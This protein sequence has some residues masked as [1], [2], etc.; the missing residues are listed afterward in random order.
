MEH[1]P[2]LQQLRQ[3]RDEALRAAEKGKA[4]L[5]QTRAEV[6][7]AR[8]EL[9]LA[10]RTLKDA[11]AA[12]EASRRELGQAKNRVAAEVMKL[13]LA[14]G[15]DFDLDERKQALVA[16]E[17]AALD[18]LRGQLRLAAEEAEEPEEAPAAQRSVGD[19]LA[20]PAAPPAAPKE[21]LDLERLGLDE[22]LHL[23]F[24]QGVL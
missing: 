13:E 11:E 21:G 14:A 6:G 19:R 9:D 23:A 24:R 2:Q 15:K 20:K 16:L 3:Q 12:S 7:K 5:E 18:A 17:L 10:Q 1:D 4:D 8:A 22:T